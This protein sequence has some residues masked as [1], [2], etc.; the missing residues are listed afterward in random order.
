MIRRSPIIL[1]FALSF[2]ACNFAPKYSRPDFS[3]PSSW[4]SEPLAGEDLSNTSWWDRFEDPEM[5]RLIALALAN[6]NDLQV[7]AWRVYEYFA[8]YQSTRSG[9]FPQITGN[10]GALKERLPVDSNFLPQGAS[11]I[12]PDYHMDLALSY[13]IDFWGSVR[14]ATTAAFQEYLAQVENRRTV[15]LT[16]IGSVA[17]AYI[18]L[19]QLNL[20]LETASKIMSS[21]EESLVIARDRFEG[22][23]TSKIEVDQAESVY[24]ETVAV[25]RE[26]EKRVPQQE[27]LLSVLLGQA[28]GPIAQGVPLNKLSLPRELP[29]CLPQDLLTRRPDILRAENNLKAANANIGIARAAFFPQLSLNGIYGADHLALKGLLERPARFWLLGGGILQQVFT[30]GRLV[31][32]LKI[33][34]AQKQELLFTYEQSIL[35]ALR[36]VDDSLIGFE[37]NQQIF[38]ADA[39]EVAALKD[40]LNLAWYR[41]YEGETQYLTVL[42]AQRQVLTAELN[43]IAAQADQFLALIELYKALGGG[44]VLQADSLVQKENTN[45][46]LNP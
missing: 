31:S 46:N 43:A 23:L 1:L 10:G 21:R 30:G 17:E 14:N 16:L 33:A 9:L 18:L 19:K 20:Q 27:N 35:T 40:Y 37:K 22:G 13:E 38:A 28:P 29:S 4:R 39:A 32:Q 6:N 11:P 26:L 36:E 25:V 7:A 44:W 15:V 41:Y 34:E 8:Q 24:E 45:R 2:S 12:T 42:D 5:G 3:M